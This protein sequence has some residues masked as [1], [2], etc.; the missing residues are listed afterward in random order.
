MIFSTVFAVISPRATRPTCRISD[1]TKGS[2]SCTKG[3]CQMLR[4]TCGTPSPGISSTVACFWRLA[5]GTGVGVICW[6]GLGL[7][8]GFGTGGSGG[9]AIELLRV[10]VL[11][12]AD[13]KG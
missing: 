4:C 13:P 1:V 2:T 11:G 8:L 6:P 3:D 7:G 10:R 12:S 9:L 5:P